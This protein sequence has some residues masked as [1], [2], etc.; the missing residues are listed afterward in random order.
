MFW[1]RKISYKVGI[2]LVVLNILLISGCA[3]MSRFQEYE[4][5]KLKQDEIDKY[6][7]GL[8]QKEK[9]KLKLGEKL[10]YEVYWIGIPAGEVVLQV[11]NETDFKGNKVYQ[12]IGKARTNKFFSVIYNINDIFKSYIDQEKGVSRGYELIRRGKDKEEVK[13]AFDYKRCKA[14]IILKEEKEKKEKNIPNGVYDPLSSLYNLRKKNIKVGNSIIMDVY[15]D[16]KNWK[17]EYNIKKFGKFN[18]VNVGVFNA[19]LVRSIV[20]HEGKIRKDRRIKFW[21]S[22]DKR[23]LPL[24]VTIDV[25]F[26]Y[27]KAVL[28][29]VES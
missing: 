24:L 20:K 8:E 16:E 4:V 19:F 26:G 10:Y 7:R 3:N 21:I 22:A 12:L 27:M 13:A 25:P 2:F 9:H 5:E 6:Q 14:E 17:V 23:R 28:R 29:K 11:K 18:L 15:V 1:K